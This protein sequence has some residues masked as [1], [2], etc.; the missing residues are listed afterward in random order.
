MAPVS[1]LIGS[2]LLAYL[3][4]SFP[5]SYLFARTI[6]GIDIRKVGS[7][8]AGATNVLRSV[9]K[10]PALVTLA[11]DILKGWMVVTIIANYF[12]TYDIDLLYDAYRGLM[13]ITV[14]CGHIWPVFLKFRGGKGVATTLGVAIGLTPF[15]L[16]PSALIWFLVFYITNFVSLASIMALIL[17]PAVACILKYPF[18]I[19][20]SSVAICSLSI[21]KHRDNIRRLVRGEESK[22]YIFKKRSA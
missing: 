9:G 6:K 19:I 5:A 21:Y 18:Y 10:V 1:A 17:F 12:Y 20:L 14:V 3:I 16:I 4:G 2:L 8:N 7:G 15:A 13:G 22:T 11:I